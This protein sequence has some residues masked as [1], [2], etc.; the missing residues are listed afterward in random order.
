MSQP[1][2]EEL[3]QLLTGEG[4]SGGA[5]KKTPKALKPWIA[6]RK[7]HP[8]MSISQQSKLY[9]GKGMD[10]EY[11]AEGAG[12]DGEYEFV[13]E[14]G[15]IKRRKKRRG[16]RKRG[17]R[18]GRGVGE[19]TVGGASYPESK[20]NTKK[21]KEYEDTKRF[22][23][24]II[25]S[26]KEHFPRKWSTMKRLTGAGAT[27][28]DFAQFAKSE[29]GKKLFGETLRK[30]WENKVLSGEY[31]SD[32]EKK[33]F[34]IGSQAMAKMTEDLVYLVETGD[35]YS[36]SGAPSAPPSATASS[37]ASG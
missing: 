15:K 9:H 29:I 17:T 3:L 1:S 11:E 22:G 23:K 19:E 26:F 2:R 37:S 18:K 24:S 25:M 21:V 32:R 7:K 20:W 4:F 10:G 27:E 13:I 6:F 14:G 30:E 12:D 35:A 31:E 8:G 5:K 28:F 16:T 33:Y 34:D 36:K